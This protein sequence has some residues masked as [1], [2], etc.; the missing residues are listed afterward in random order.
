M[1]TRLQVEHP[2]TEVV[3]GIDLVSWQIRVA[4]G[5]RLDIDA[6]AVAVPRGHA[7]ECRIYAEDAD[8]GFVPSPG[9]LTWLRTPD[10]PGIRHDSGID[11]GG[12]VPVFYDAMMAKLVAWGES[13]DQSV[14]R[15]RRALLEYRVGGVRT[16]IPFFLWLL[17]QP[18]FQSASFHTTYLDEVL[19]ERAGVPFSTPDV[20]LEEVAIVAAALYHAN[21]GSTPVAEVP[22]AWKARARSEGLRQ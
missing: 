1:N 12:R 5:E 13:R 3:T 15:M 22:S 4:R 2:V 10:G 17:D 19:H 6:A 16:S 14:A 18:E 7:I 20:S 9:R 21:R 8:A 11:T